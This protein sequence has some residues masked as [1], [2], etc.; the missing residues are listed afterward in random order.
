M[1]IPFHE[2][3]A[4]ELGFQKLSHSFKELFSNFSFHL[5]LLD[6]VHFQ[7]FLVLIIF[8]F[9]KHSDSFLIWLLYSLCCFF[10]A[11]FHYDYGSFFNVKFHSCALVVYS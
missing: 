5:C 8:L 6:G 9:F 4:A 7:Y 2:I 11:T 1:S 3:S 10:F